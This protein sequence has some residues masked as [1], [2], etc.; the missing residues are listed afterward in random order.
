V[1]DK[2]DGAVLLADFLDDLGRFMDGP[3]MF[4]LFLLMFAIVGIVS[5]C[6]AIL[7]PDKVMEAR[8]MRWPGSDP[9]TVKA[10]GYFNLMLGFLALGVSVYIFLVR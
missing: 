2:L 9:T 10:I 6:Y 1:T 8:R 3:L 4:P 7:W 5:G